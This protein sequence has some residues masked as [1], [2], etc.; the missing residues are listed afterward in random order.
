MF[1]KKKMLRFVV[2]IRSVTIL[3]TYLKL[4]NAL[5]HR[6]M[7][8]DPCFRV[9]TVPSSKARNNLALKIT[10]INRYYYTT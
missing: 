3:N 1:T 10:N 4:L 5:N 7:F 9:T 8:N 2:L 6:L